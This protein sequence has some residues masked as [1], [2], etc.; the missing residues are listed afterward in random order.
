MVSLSAARRT[1]RGGET[2]AVAVFVALMTVVLFTIAALIV[3]L[4]LARDTRRQAQNTAD[5]ASLAAANAL[6]LSG[7]ASPVAA[8]DAAKT[9]AASNFGTT[10]ADWVGCEDPERPPGFVAVP[11]QTDCISFSGLPAPKEV[12]VV[13]PTR[14][15]KTTLGGMLGVDNMPIH[16][17]AHAVVDPGGRSTCGLCVIGPGVHEFQN[18]S[19]TVV[20]TSAYING[21][22]DAN[23]QMELTASGGQVYLEGS[24][25]TQGLIIPAPYTSQPAIPDPL[26]FLTLPLP[27]TGLTA[28]T[29]SACSPAG[30][31][32]I[33]ESLDLSDDCVLSPGLYVV[34][35]ENHDSGQTQVTANGV[36]LYFGCQDP[37]SAAP[38]LR[39]CNVG[40]EGGDLLLTG[41]AT[42]DI[43]APSTGPSAGLAVVADRNNTATIGWRGNGATQSTGTIYLKSGRLDYRGNGAGSSLDALVV[44]DDMTF[45]G[46]PAHF[47]LS[48]TEENNVVLPAGALH[49]SQ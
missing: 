20:G 17:L 40:E 43:T 32:G 45:E 48:Y 35:G 33:Y 14:N 42:L 38:K 7:A 36:T 13:V 2:G 27:T 16:A 3:D 10:D 41:K 4:G 44:V 6:Y 29:V 21:T 28:K 5:A 22:L 23:P 11:G 37:S 49:L 31:P 26:G 15:L 9:Y 24:K 1:A 12:R 8:I 34:T 18:G 47:E 30:G 46:N 19:V 39:D 25:P